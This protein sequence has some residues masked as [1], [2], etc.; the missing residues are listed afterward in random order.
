ML[1]RR[2]SLSRGREGVNKWEDELFHLQ[3]RLLFGFNLGVPIFDFAKNIDLESTLQA[4]EISVKFYPGNHVHLILAISRAEK[5]LKTRFRRD[6]V[7]CKRGHNMKIEGGLRTDSNRLKR[8]PIQEDYF[9]SL[10]LTTQDFG[11]WMIY[12]WTQTID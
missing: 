11:G 8:S 10:L 4:G 9:V 5:F 1:S 12:F 6:V 7:W 3:L 2:V